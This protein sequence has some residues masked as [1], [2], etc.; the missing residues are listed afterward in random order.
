MHISI[1]FKNV[2]YT[3]HCFPPTLKGHSGPVR[4][5]VN[6][7]SDHLVLSGAQDGALLMHAIS[8]SH[9][10]RETVAL[11]QPSSTPEVYQT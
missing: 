11:S 6:S 3:V 7:A 8:S 2:T 9:S 10:L 4:A 5:V 1:H